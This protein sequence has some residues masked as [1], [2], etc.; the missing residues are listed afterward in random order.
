MLDVASVI[1]AKQV[2]ALT[3]EIDPLETRSCPDEV[4]FKFWYLKVDFSFL[5]KNQ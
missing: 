2:K 5:V 1:L 4:Y 3:S